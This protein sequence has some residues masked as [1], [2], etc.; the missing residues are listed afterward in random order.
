GAV[1]LQVRDNG[2]GFVPDAPRKPYSLGL[3]GLRERTQLLKGRVSIDSR[4]GHG[5]CIDVHIPV[6]E[7]GASL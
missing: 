3:M 2:R 6:S 5:T 1:V 7:P 4:P